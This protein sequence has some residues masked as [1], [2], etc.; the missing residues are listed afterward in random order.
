MKIPNFMPYVSTMKRLLHNNAPIILAGVGVAGTIATA[1]SSG[2]A[3]IKAYKVYKEQ[4]DMSPKQMVKTYAPIF[5]PPVLMGATTIASIVCGYRAHEKQLAAMLALYKASESYLSDYKESVAELLKGDEKP[6]VEKIEAAT[7]DKQ[8]K[9]M[10]EKDENHI[11]PIEET[12]HGH[13]LCYDAVCGRY[14]Y[15][16][17]E[18][19]RQQVNNLNEEMFGGE[20][21]I[22]LN[23][24]YD[25]IGLD[26]TNIGEDLGWDS[27]R[28]P[29]KLKL[30]S[31]IHPR[32]KVAA[33]VV[34]FEYLIHT[35]EYS[36]TTN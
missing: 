16:N 30:Q 32:R 23:R 11:S 10:V 15:S 25:A 27:M 7:D 12:E 17:A 26:Q 22:G 24:F 36:D 18:W 29:I 9:A 28:G 1:I 3:G 2:Q 5:L 6:S 31:R 4:P 35:T 13:D 8:W 19:I 20:D 21:W 14:F 34:D 33:L